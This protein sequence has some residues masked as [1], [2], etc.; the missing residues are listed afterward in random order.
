MIIV[1]KLNNRIGCEYKIQK[2]KTKNQE[3]TKENFNTIVKINKKT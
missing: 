1:K 3:Q 2:R